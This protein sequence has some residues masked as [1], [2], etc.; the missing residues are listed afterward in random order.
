MKLAW[1]FFVCSAALALS[2][3]FALRSFYATDSI[4]AYRSPEAWGIE[5]WSGR[6]TFVTM[7][8]LRKG[9]PKGNWGAEGRHDFALLDYRRAKPLTIF[10]HV[11][12]MYR[13]IGLAME[14]NTSPHGFITVVGVPY[15]L[16][17]IALLCLDVLLWKRWRHAHRKLHNCCV[18]CGYDLRTSS[19]RCSECGNPIME[20]TSDANTR[21]LENQ[22]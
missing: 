17:I 8:S 4:V 18:K 7:S 16:V 9:E 1:K 6:L 12:F 5:S 3:V 10:E 11:G 20:A 13:C 19:D 22:P 21:E 2:S 14:E 15:C